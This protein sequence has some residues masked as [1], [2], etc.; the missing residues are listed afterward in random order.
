VN[1]RTV[2]VT[3]STQSGAFT[4]AV[5]VA[6]TVTDSLGTAMGSPNMTTFAGFVTPAVVR[7]NEVNL[8]IQTGVN[9][10]VCDLIELRVVSGGAMSG[11]FLR[12]RETGTLVTFANFFVNTN[13]IIVVHLNTANTMCNPAAATFETTAPNQQPM[14]AH[15]RN[16]DTAYDWY[17]ADTGLTSTDNVITLYNNLNVIMDA[18]FV[19]DDTAGSNVAAATET[20]AA[21][22]ATA[23][24]WQMVGGGIPT[25]GFVDDNFR[26]HAVLESDATGTTATGD[27]IQRV[28]NSDDNDKADWNASPALPHSWGLLN[29][30]Q[31]PF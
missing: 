18:V 14:S 25:G 26:L 7:I 24:Q 15:S 22:V 8:N 5:T 19:D 21:T 2:T 1:G 27:T 17:S 28:D 12:E 9:T 11:Y 30:G 23:N 3:T 6:N 29:A 31:T 16:Y 4:Y 20:Q 10:N 13:D